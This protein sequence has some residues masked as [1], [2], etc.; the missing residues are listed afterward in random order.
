MLNNH[1]LKDWKN[2][3]FK[4]LTLNN[5]CE[6]RKAQALRSSI[7]LRAQH[8]QREHSMPIISEDKVDKMKPE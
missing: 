8:R 2:S 3:G 7:L 1:D 4:T 5:Q 6:I